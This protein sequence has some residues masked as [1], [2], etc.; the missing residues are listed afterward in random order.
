MNDKLK[1]LFDVEK[2]TTSPKKN[3]IS[4]LHIDD[5]KLNEDGEVLMHIPQQNVIDEEKLADADYQEELIEN[6]QPKAK[7][8]LT[9]YLLEAME[10]HNL[11]GFDYL[12][13][14]HVLRMA[15]EADQE[16]ATCFESSLN[17]AKSMGV[18]PEALM[19]AAEHYIQVLEKADKKFE[20]EMMLEVINSIEK[21]EKTIH[22]IEGEIEEKEEE[23][24][25]LERLLALK[26]KDLA[27]RKKSIAQKVVKSEQKKM[28]FL[29]SYNY[30]LQE[31]REDIEKIQ[32]YQ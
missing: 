5:I 27:Q 23:I 20:E 9:N 30:L 4:E 2:D 13:F 25:Y 3:P 19:K 15:R 22:Q 26:R 14:R 8:E 1:N 10:A 12:E 6:Y 17:L 11:E 28:D 24:L 16:E 21:E 31:I 32:K 29:L 7:E 18:S